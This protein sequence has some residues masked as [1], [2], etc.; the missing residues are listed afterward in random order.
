MTSS[1]GQD[2]SKYNII[3]LK[4]WKDPENPISRGMAS[5]VFGL[6][7]FGYALAQH[8]HPLEVILPAI[9]ILGN[10][11]FRNEFEIPCD[12]YE[13]KCFLIAR[14]LPNFVILYMI[15]M[16]V[17]RILNGNTSR[18]DLALVPIGAT[19]IY[20]LIQYA[21]SFWNMDKVLKSGENK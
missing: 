5:T 8:A 21:R 12:H 19:Y 4:F 16:N 1:K 3:S 7:W 17:I 11:K 13:P 6:G 2:E 15:T 18:L 9:A 20:S 10:M 14:I